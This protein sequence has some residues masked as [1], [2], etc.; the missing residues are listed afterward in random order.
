MQKISTILN[1][2]LPTIN[3]CESLELSG[4]GQTREEAF[5]MLTDSI[6]DI[7]NMLIGGIREEEKK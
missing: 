2:K 6:K 7:F 3:I 4:Y 5:E 1:S